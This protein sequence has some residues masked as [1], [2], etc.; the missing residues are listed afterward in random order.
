MTRT[1]RSVVACC[2]VVLAGVLAGPLPGASASKQSIKSALKSYSGP[3]AV[4]EGHT[5]TALGEYK[6]THVAAPVEEA[7]TKSVTVITALRSKIA[8]QTAVA[9]KTKLAKAKLLKG[10]AGVIA[11]YEK[12]KTVYSLKTSSPEAAQMEAEKALVAI[13]SAKRQL[14]EAAKLLT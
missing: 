12:L 1:K 5:L 14:S 4:A 11:A 7:I 6:S 3:V 9:T 2:L 8:H 10:L 13:K